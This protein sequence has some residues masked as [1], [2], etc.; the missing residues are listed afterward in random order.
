MRHLAISN[1]IKNKA[2]EKQNMKE[3]IKLRNDDYNY[4]FSERARA[5]SRS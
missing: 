5:M 3:M 1:I 2:K 4:I